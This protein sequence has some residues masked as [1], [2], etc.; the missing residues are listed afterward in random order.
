MKRVQLAHGNIAP[1][2]ILLVELI[3][4][5]R[6]DAHPTVL[7]AL[8]TS[9]RSRWPGSPRS[10]TVTPIGQGPT[11][12]T[13][14]DPL[15][16]LDADDLRRTS[17]LTRHVRTVTQP[18]WEVIY[19]QKSVRPGNMSVDY[20]LDVFLLGETAEAASMIREGMSRDAII[21]WLDAHVDQV[22]SD[23]KLVE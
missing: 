11:D 13:E 7:V 10:K 3:K 5:S 19:I 12:D 8:P 23:W 17:G 22:F 16:D 6:P 4:N 21:N 2:S 14:Q 15:G 20:P 18:G 9:V 1:A